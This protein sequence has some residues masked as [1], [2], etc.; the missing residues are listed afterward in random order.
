MA[1]VRIIVDHMKLIYNGLFDVNDLFRAIDAWLFERGYEKY[2]NRADEILT[3]T[4]KFIEWE[5]RPWKKISEYNR[6]FMKIRILMYDVKK[7]DVV[8]ENKKIKLSQ[9]RSI[10]TFDGFIEFDY[11]HRWD[12][13]PLLLFFR[14]L[15][16]KFIYKAYTERFEQQLSF[17][18][19]QLYDHIEKFF[20]TY[21]YYRVVTKVPHFAH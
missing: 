7:V 14:T 9:G 8:H 12:E 19:H 18:M 2:T 11:E 10:I 4:G 6:Y 15:Y 5:S 1:E 20:N 21:K 16:D 3:P 17:D 13:K